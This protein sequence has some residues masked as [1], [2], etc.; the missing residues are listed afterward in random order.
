MQSTSGLDRPF[1]RRTG[2]KTLPGRLKWLAAALKATEEEVQTAFRHLE[3]KGLVLLDTPAS[4]TREQDILVL[5]GAA[6]RVLT[7]TEA[8]IVDHLLQ[9]ERDPRH[10]SVAR[11]PGVCGGEWVVR[12]TG[13]AIE[14]IGNYFHAGKGTADI[15]RDFPFLMV[16]EILD[17]FHAYLDR[18]LDQRDE[19]AAL[20]HAA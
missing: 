1:R 7:A 8:A 14:A 16:D 11:T 12:G 15:Q 10:P 4:E 19:P 9:T 18:R 3:E 2:F 20:E 13:I 17:A 6:R 5:P